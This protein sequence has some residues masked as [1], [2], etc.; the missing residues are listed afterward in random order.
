MEWVAILNIVLPQVFGIVG[1]MRKQ[2]PSLTYEQALRKAGVNVDAEVLRL[3]AEM[4]KAVQEGAVP[5]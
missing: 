5:R 4:A 3:M 2:D 1:D